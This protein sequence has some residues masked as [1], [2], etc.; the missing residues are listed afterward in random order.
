MRVCVCVSARIE[1]KISHNFRDLQPTGRQTCLIWCLAAV[2]VYAPYCSLK[3]P[4][5]KPRVKHTLSVHFRTL[6]TLEY[7]SND[8]ENEA[9][10]FRIVYSLPNYRAADI[11]DKREG[12][13]RDRGG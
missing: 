13:G 2:C 5:L 7:S 3:L 9:A 1:A 6:P 12:S 10:M 4:A 8:V 11:C